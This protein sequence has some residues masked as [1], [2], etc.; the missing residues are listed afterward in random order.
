MIREQVGS[1]GASGGCSHDVY[2]VHAVGDH[3]QTQDVCI[4]HALAYITST[5]FLEMHDML[6]VSDSLPCAATKRMRQIALVVP[7]CRQSLYLPVVGS[8]TKYRV[9]VR[10]CVVDGCGWMESPPP[11]R[12]RPTRCSG[13]ARN[14]YYRR[15]L[16][17]VILLT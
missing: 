15:K 4:Q 6:G 9:K 13:L 3:E 7:C 12:C 11:S 10:C 8:T 2:F 16:R 14:K 17:V 5:I 1:T